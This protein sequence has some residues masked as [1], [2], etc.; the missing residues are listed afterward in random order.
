MKMNRRTNFFFETNTSKTC[1]AIRPQS[2]AM[3]AAIS[4][5][6]LFLFFKIEILPSLLLWYF[7]ARRNGINLPCAPAAPA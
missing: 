1:A 3:P 2:N 4:K 5:S 6:F 7:I